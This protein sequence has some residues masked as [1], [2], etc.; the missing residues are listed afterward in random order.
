ME[1]KQ[2]VVGLLLLR[3]RVRCREKPFNSK[4]LLPFDNQSNQIYK[5][6]NK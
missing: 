1:N 3:C 6:K 5:E 2:L 4:A